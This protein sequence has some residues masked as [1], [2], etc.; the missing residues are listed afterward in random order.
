M[1]KTLL[2]VL[3]SFVVIGL[4]LPA[5]GRLEAQSFTAQML[6]SAIQEGNVTDADLGVNTPKVLPGN[7]F[8]LFKEAGR[9]IQ[10]F[11]TF[12]SVKKAELKLKWSP[13]ASF[14]FNDKV[15]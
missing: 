12:G 5:L 11:F 14:D 15:T 2:V 13:K 3:S 7:P 1:K 10:Q 9:G 8:Y 6:E 4:A